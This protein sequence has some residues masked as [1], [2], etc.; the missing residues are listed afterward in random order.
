[1]ID[2]DDD[3]EGVLL[4]YESAQ[5]VLEGVVRV[6]DVSSRQLKICCLFVASAL[7]GS[8]QFLGGAES[9]FGRMCVL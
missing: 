4:V 5:V 3:A 1:M 9:G 7:K 6:V 8:A 2:F